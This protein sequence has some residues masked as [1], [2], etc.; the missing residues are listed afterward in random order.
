[1]RGRSVAAVV[2]AVAVALGA[3]GGCA[4]DGA[5]DELVA[6][7]TTTG[8]AAPPSTTAAPPG[9]D[10]APPPADEPPRADVFGLAVGT[11]FDDPSESVDVVDVPVVPCDAPHDNEVYAVFDLA[12]DVYPGDEAVQQSA[13]EGC[14]ERL[15]SLLGTDPAATPL[16]A[17]FLYPV[18]QGWEQIGDREVVC[19][20]FRRDLAKLTGSLAATGW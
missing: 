6:G 17:S 2:A 15:V 13:S 4:D 11:C 16:E 7:I 19:F 10:P 5:L 9:A 1:M 14:L 18:Q 12:G 20:A 8:G 3:A